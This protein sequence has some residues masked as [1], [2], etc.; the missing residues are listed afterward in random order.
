MWAEAYLPYANYRGALL[1]AHEKAWVPLDPGFKRL[2]SAGGYDVREAGF[3]PVAGVRR[4]PRR[5]AVRV[6]PR[7]FYRQR[8]EAALAGERAGALLRARPWRDAT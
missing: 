8:A 7:E 6:T 1:D 4:L 2:V 3:D 5:G